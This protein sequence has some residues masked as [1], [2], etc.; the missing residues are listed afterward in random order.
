[1]DGREFRELEAKFMKELVSE[2]IA[3]RVLLEEH[4]G[5]TRKLNTADKIPMQTAQKPEI[6]VERVVVPPV[7]EKKVSP[8][9]NTRSKE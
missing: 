3:I 8:K 4:V 6:P 7:I 5:S 2:L 1:M 9:R